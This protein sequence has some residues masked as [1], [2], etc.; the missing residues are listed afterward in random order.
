MAGAGARG[1]LGIAFGMTTEHPD[2]PVQ[3]RR[4]ILQASDMVERSAHIVH[5]WSG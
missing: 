5:G 4:K 3:L 2:Y 1:M